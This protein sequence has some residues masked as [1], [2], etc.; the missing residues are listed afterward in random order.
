MA[1]TGLLTSKSPNLQSPVTQGTKDGMGMGLQNQI[2]NSNMPNNV[3]MSNSMANSMPMSMSN[4][5][6]QPMS[7]MQGTQINIL[8]LLQ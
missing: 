8:Y 7:S 2:I 6:N 3:C 5:N 1:L 4:S